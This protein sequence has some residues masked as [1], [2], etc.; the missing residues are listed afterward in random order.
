MAVQ[1]AAAVD[2]FNSVLFLC[3]CS[4]KMSLI[5]SGTV[6]SQSLRIFLPTLFRW[7]NA[8]PKDFSQSQKR[9][10]QKLINTLN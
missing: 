10:T 3:A 1:L 6:L 8:G 2:V 7:A 4:H 5:R 9:L